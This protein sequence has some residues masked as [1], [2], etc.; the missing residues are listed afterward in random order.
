MVR[1]GGKV[2]SMKVCTAG[3]SNGL[4]LFYLCSVW[5]PDAKG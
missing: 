3:S 2:A 5:N 4:F 1:H